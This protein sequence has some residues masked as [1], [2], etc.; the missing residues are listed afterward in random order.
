MEMLYY[1]MEMIPSVNGIEAG[2]IDEHNR[3][4]FIFQIYPNLDVK[5]GVIL[6]MKKNRNYTA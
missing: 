1:E 4:F 2:G 6:S 5:N 3:Y